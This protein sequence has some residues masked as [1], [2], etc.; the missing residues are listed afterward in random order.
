M[1]LGRPLTIKEQ[2][3]DMG[4]RQIG[5][6]QAG[7]LIAARTLESAATLAQLTLVDWQADRR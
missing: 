2:R 3:C 6:E 1:Q 7:N 5:T 4:E